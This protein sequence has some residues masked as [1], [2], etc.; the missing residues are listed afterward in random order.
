MIMED[1]MGPKRL[2]KLAATMLVLLLIRTAGAGE[3][4]YTFGVLNQRNPVLTAQ[5]WNPILEYVSKKSGITLQLQMGKTVQETDDMTERGEFDFIFSNHIFMSRISRTG[6]NVI[7]KPVE[8]SIQGQIVVLENTP[9]HTLEDLEGKEIAFPSE[10]AFVAYA[11]TMD[12]IQQKGI[13]VKPVFAGNQEGVMG[14]LK[15]GRVPAA[16][17]NSQVML[18]FARRQHIKFRVLWS[19]EKFAPMPI[20]VHRRV[21]KKQVK[22]VQEALVRMASDPEGLRVLQACAAVVKQSPPL[23]FVTANDRDYENQRNFYRKTMLKGF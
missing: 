9:L 7:V 20:A 4:A 21:G 22:A 15:A 23:G 11:V 10:T 2:V 12:A 8:E 5:Y 1:I 14:Q 3:K 19:S 6:Y 13:H 16:S 17:V 18:E